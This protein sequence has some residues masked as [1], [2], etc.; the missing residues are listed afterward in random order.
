MAIPGHLTFVLIIWRLTTD[1]T[2]LSFLFIF[3]Y[4]IAA[5][6]QVEKKFFFKLIKFIWIV[7]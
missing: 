7:L 1:H 4:L 6:I 5:L 3:L 2:R